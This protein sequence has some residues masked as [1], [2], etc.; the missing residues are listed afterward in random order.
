MTH[1]G[2]GFTITPPP[3]CSD[4]VDNDNDGGIDFDPV[5]FANPGNKTTPPSGTGDPGC[6]FPAWGTERPPCQDGIDNDGDG[7]I[8]YEGG[9][10]ALGYVAAEPDPYCTR[11][12]SWHMESHLCGLGVEL[13][14]LLPP[15][16]WLWRRRSPH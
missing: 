7:K 16:M 8:V 15:L 6:L 1:D 12:P 13:A 3:A 4:G 14:L 11:R 10:S 5:T 2:L 9:R